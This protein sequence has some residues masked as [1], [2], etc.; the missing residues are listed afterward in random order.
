LF[1]QLGWSAANIGGSG[2][3][4][5]QTYQD[6]EGNYWIST[7]SGVFRVRGNA[8]EAVATDLK[9]RALL[10]DRDGGL[11]IGTNGDGLG[12]CKRAAVGCSW[13]HRMHSATVARLNWRARLPPESLKDQ[14]ASDRFL[15]L[16][17]GPCVR[18]F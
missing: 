6:T 9:C 1:R 12:L 16:I 13:S 4:A 2:N 10:V 11:W 17:S 14:F 15:A 8:L 18:I 5:Y 7:D 3:G